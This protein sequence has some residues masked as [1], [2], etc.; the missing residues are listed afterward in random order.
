M[1]CQLRSD[2]F[3][4]CWA[5]PHCISFQS[6][7]SSVQRRLHLQI[8]NAV[9]PVIDGHGLF[10]LLLCLFDQLLPSGSVKLN[11]CVI[12]QGPNGRALP[13]P[14]F[15]VPCPVTQMSLGLKKVSKP[16]QLNWKLPQQNSSAARS[17][18]RSFT[19]EEGLNYLHHMAGRKSL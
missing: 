19:Q 1:S 14:T 8:G 4:N 11:V 12:H 10:T 15:L 3:G 5:R 6:F 9:L 13:T 16:C 2:D 7:A 17:K 18:S